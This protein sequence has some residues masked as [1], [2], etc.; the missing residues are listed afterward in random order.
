MAL[1]HAVFLY[2]LVDI[3]KLELAIGRDVNNPPSLVQEEV[4]YAM[5]WASTPSAKRAVIHGTLLQKQLAN[6]PLDA[7]PAIHVPRALFHT[8]VVWYC[9]A[10]FAPQVDDGRNVDREW[11]EMEMLGVDT[12]KIPGAGGSGRRVIEKAN[13]CALTDMLRRVG[14]WGIARRFARIL[15]ELVFEGGGN[16]W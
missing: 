11:D 10:K 3:N 8:G 16:E 1:W 9:W 2:L 14:H 4:A 13:L 6:T 15:G 7:E 12:D 5:K